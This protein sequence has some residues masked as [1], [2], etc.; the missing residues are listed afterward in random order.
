MTA[1]NKFDDYKYV[2]WFKED[3]FG[4]FIHFGLYSMLG[5]KWRGQTCRGIAEWI[6]NSL[7]I[8][9]EEYRKLADKFDPKD[10]DPTAICKLARRAGMRYLCL[11]AKHHEGFALW[12]SKVSSY[13]SVNSPCSRDIVREF[14]EACARHDL[15]FCLYYSQAQDWEDPNG[16]MAYRDGN[17]EKDFDLYFQN[18]C[19][20]QLRELLTSYGKI[21]MIWFDTPMG[22]TEKHAR[23][24]R[25]F[26]K[27]L[28]ESCLISGR[29]GHGMGDY[30]TTGDNMLPSIPSEKLWELPA[31]INQSWGYKENDKNWRSSDQIIRELY[32]AVSLGGN[33]LLNIGPDGNGS[34]PQESVRV[35]E[36]VGDFIASNG[37][38]LY[39]TEIQGAYPYK[40]DDFILTGKKNHLYILLYDLNKTSRIELFNLQNKIRNVRLLLTGDTIDY[41]DSFDLEGHH[42]LLINLND[43]DEKLKPVNFNNMLVID[44]E[45]DGDRAEFE[46]F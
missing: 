42:Y 34:V 40:Q 31:T 7:D 13:N 23:E 39:G 8:P 36:Q 30:R 6:Q 24:L 18:K 22:M 26:V 37:A 44:I 9:L 25:D 17:E 28:Q 46:E 1:M 21:S 3:K 4:M 20:P 29:I 12:D 10:L 35:L 27:S 2:S 43:I 33:Y 11:T 32:S 38:S 41:H 15:K 45:H 14:S 16:Y 5:G 19:L